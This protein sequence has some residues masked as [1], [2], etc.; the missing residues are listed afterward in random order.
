MKI[1]TFR[2]AAIVTAAALTLFCANAGANTPLACKLGAATADGHNIDVVNTT[3]KTLANET[4]INI[5][6]STKHPESGGGAGDCF[7]LDAP[8][9]PKAHVNHVIKLHFGADA[10]ICNA[11]VSSKYPSV[12]HDSSGGAMTMCDNN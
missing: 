11:F 3:T 2:P 6:L 10:T 1:A 4:V 12:V 9:A 7:A 8:L 5:A